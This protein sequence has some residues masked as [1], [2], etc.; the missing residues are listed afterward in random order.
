MHT[1][2]AKIL[3]EGVWRDR[4]RIRPHRGPGRHR[5]PDRHG[6]QP[7]HHVQHG[8][9]CAFRRDRRLSATCDKV[10]ANKFVEMWG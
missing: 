7:R 8:L 2:L 10:E 6:Q 3:G 9:E 1:K 4:H 5:R